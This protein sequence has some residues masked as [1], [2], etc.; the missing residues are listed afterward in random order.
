MEKT[1]NFIL[2]IGILIAV[3]FIMEKYN[4]KKIKSNLVNVENKTIEEFNMDRIYNENIPETSK[5][6]FDYGVKPIEEQFIIEQEMGVNL[7]TWYPNTW[8]EKIDENNQT[9]YNSRENITG[10]KD[11][12]VEAKAL[13]SYLF[14]P[15]RNINIGGVVNPDDESVSLAIK[16]VY[17]KSFIDYKKLANN[18]KMI[19]IEPDNNIIKAASNLN[20]FSND[21]WVYQ[22]E[23]PE[24]GGIIYDGISASDPASIGTVAQF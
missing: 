13:N 16:D 6:S 9:I 5:I 18:K 24:N 7:N 15:Q 17:D 4:N 23:K 20:Y 8:I 22:N 10:Q 21:T 19:E 11:Q 1:F 2:I 3:Y 12:Y 14:D